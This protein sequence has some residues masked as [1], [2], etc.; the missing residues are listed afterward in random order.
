MLRTELLCN[1]VV[2]NYLPYVSVVSCLKR[3]AVQQDARSTD[4]ERGIEDEEEGAGSHH[5]ERP[6]QATVLS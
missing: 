4:R 3:R 1:F 6:Q 2:G 5:E